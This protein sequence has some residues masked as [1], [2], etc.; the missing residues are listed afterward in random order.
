MSQGDVEILRKALEQA[1]QDPEAFYAVID[2]AV[3]W[4]TTRQV[5]DGDVSRGV[6]GV[7]RFFRRWEGPLARYE[8]V[9]EEVVDMGDQVFTVLC[10]RASGRGSGAPVER[11]IAQIWTFRGGRVVR[12]RGFQDKT[13]AL[14]AAASPRE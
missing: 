9:L 6:A 5:P 14:R 7:H 11:R 4:D 3:E 12:Y 1:S 10:E 8:Y 13:E 2:P